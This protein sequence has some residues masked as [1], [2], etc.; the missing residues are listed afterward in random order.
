MADQ[1]ISGQ[2]RSLRDACGRCCGF[3]A[4]LV[5]GVAAWAGIFMV[6]TRF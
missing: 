6:L 1:T 2:G 5:A 3:A 4:L